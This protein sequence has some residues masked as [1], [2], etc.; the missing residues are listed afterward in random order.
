MMRTFLE[1]VVAIGASVEML[2]VLKATIALALGLTAVRIA[3][4]GRASVRHLLLISTFG[5]LVALPIAMTVVPVVRLEIPTKAMI[6]SIASPAIARD[7]A[8][9]TTRASRIDALPVMSGEWISKSGQTLLEAVWAIGAAMF[10]ATFRQ[11][12]LAAATPPA[13]WRAMARS[14]R[15]ASR[16]RR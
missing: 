13:L 1:A 6:S 11:R 10:W 4:S 5:T 2:V 16:A 14:A 7:R 9:P 8:I 3:R 12:S 15:Y